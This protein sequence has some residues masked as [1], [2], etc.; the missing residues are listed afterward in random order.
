M[1]R[2]KDIPP[3]IVRNGLMH[4]VDWVPTLLEAVDSAASTSLPSS[5]THSLRDGKPSSSPRQFQVKD[6]G[7]ES[8]LGQGSE[9]G[10]GVGDGDFSYGGAADDGTDGVSQW[11]Y[12]TMQE[13]SAPRTEVHICIIILPNHF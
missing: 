4:L 11:R 2:G 5:P 9:E 10:D 12:L 1:V 3:G 7:E 13:D 6:G 8:T